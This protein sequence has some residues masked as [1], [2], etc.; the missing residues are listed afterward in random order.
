MTSPSFMIERDY[1]DFLVGDEAHLGSR[2]KRALKN[3]WGNESCMTL[4]VDAEGLPYTFDLIHTQHH[5]LAVSDRVVLRVTTGH[6]VPS[7]GTLEMRWRPGT[8][9]LFEVERHRF[10]SSTTA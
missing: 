5:R 1:I 6:G 7:T 4:L 10:V 8:C 3:F 9:G 2:K